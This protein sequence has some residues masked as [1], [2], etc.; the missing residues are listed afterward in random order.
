MRFRASRPPAVASFSQRDANWRTADNA[1]SGSAGWG[2]GNRQ[3]PR[4]DPAKL[5]VIASAAMLAIFLSKAQGQILVANTTANPV[6]IASYNAATGALINSALVSDPLNSVGL[7]VSGADLFTVSPG[8]TVGEFTTSGAAINAALF[9]AQSGTSGI[10]VSGPVL[11][12]TNSGNGT[13]GEYM[14]SGATV[15]ASLITGLSAPSGIAICG[16]NL[17]VANQAT[18]TVGEYTTSGATVNASLITG[19][20]APRGIPI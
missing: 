13:V 1:R 8:G 6:A 2:C 20:S 16:T 19:R 3:A 5:R 10:A 11:F 17:F 9:S 15:N 4:K 12:I 18:G 7:A 14:N